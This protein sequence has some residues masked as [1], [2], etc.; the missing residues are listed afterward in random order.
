MTGSFLLFRREK[1]LLG[2]FTSEKTSKL[3][4]LRKPKKL[5]E[6]EIEIVHQKFYNFPLFSS[7]LISS[8]AKSSFSDLACQTSVRKRGQDCDLFKF[9]IRLICSFI[10]FFAVNKGPCSFDKQVMLLF[11]PLLL[12]WLFGTTKPSDVITRHTD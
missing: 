3:C 5:T 6:L 12:F 8:A 10:P 9:L 7:D 11:Q 2:N 1:K 4:W